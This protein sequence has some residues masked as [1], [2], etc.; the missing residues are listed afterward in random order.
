MPRLNGFDCAAALKADKSCRHIPIMMLTVIEDAQR[1]Y[2]LG[3]EAYITKPFEPS[4]VLEEVN[5]IINKRAI[6]QSVVVLGECDTQDAVY[7]MLEESRVT[8][9]QVTDIAALKDT[10]SEKNHTLVIVVDAK[11][12]EKELRLEIQKIAGT[13][14]CLVLH[15]S[16]PKTP[17]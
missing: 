15:V 10:I 14:S 16:D 5:K 11:F 4:D 6:Q 2:G 7:K 12:Q 1:A 8:W 17:V 13:D 9:T 3:V